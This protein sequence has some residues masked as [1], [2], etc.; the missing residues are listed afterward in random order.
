MNWQI[1]NQDIAPS[2]AKGVGIRSAKGNA[3][4][5]GA[6]WNKQFAGL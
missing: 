2:A 3:I 5:A 4:N 1:A 6:S